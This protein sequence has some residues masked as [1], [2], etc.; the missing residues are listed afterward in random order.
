MINSFKSHSLNGV[1]ESC[2][3]RKFVGILSM[4]RIGVTEKMPED[5]TYG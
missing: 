2:L 4:Y 3:A 1:E 5:M